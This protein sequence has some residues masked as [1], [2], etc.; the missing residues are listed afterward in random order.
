MTIADIN[1]ILSRLADNPTRENILDF[2]FGLL[3]WMNIE[4]NATNKP[5]LL[6]PQTQKLKEYLATAPQTVQPQLYRLTAENQNIRVRFAVLKKLKKEYISQL[7]DNDPGLSSYQAFVKGLTSQQ[8]GTGFVPTQP[9]FIH[10]VTTP[11]Y[12]KL[13]LIFNQGEQKRIL[14]FRK[15]LSQ[16]QYNRIIQLWSGIA[17]KPKPEIADLLWKSLDI[18]EVNKDFYKKI[19]GGFDDLVGI[20]KLEKLSTNENQIKQFAVRLIGRYIFCWFLKEKNIIPQNLIDSINIEGSK[21]FHQDFLQKH[22]GRNFRLQKLP[23]RLQ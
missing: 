21:K 20:I 6:S 4:P 8:N 3:Q 23:Y 9:Y 10:F 15:R 19:K 2:S 11:D 7:V 17:S 18:K 13:V 1:K 22:R 16:T 12:D 14:S 5:Q